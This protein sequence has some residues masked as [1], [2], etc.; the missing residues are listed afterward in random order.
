VSAST[1]LDRVVAGETEIL[2]GRT[3]GLLANP[4]SV[5]RSLVHAIDRLAAAPK[6]DLV[7]LFGPEH[8]LRGTAQ[9]MIAVAETTD[10]RTGLPVVGLYGSTL[11]T[12]APKA[13]DL[14][15][16][17]ALVFDLQDVGARYY[18][19]IWTLL[20]SMRACAD[21]GV[22]V[23]VLDR[24]NPLG[25][26]VI[27]GPPIDAGF[28]SFV[29]L[30]SLPNRHGMTAGEIARLLKSR[31][32]IG[33]ELE[34]VAMAG[35]SRSMW[36]DETGLPWVMPSPN[37]PTLETA[38]VYP[39]MCL[40]E[41]TELSEGRGTTRP[42]ELAGAPGIDSFALAE[43]L[44]AEIDGAM[45]RPVTFEPTFQ[46]HAGV[47]CGGVQIHVTDRDRYPTTRAGV[48][49]ILAAAEL[50]GER[51]DW[52]TRAYEFVDDI[53][54]IDLLAGSAKLR[55]GIDARASLA[56]LT[57]SWGASEASF[58]AEREDALLY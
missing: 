46:K 27:E 26:T 1:G 4:A 54:A 43:R 45:F 50:L 18:T 24:P 39:G 6:V 10:P 22:A 30:S 44:A 49:F 12:L 23:V 25:G 34:V 14:A 52:R 5:D 40:V 35:W 29:G 58:A 3:I 33:V 28:E 36:F 42:F 31:E 41:G 20:L 11:E 55:A 9:D 17:D 51:F 7:R 16:L 53:P 57:S 2:A 21:A 13:E 47:A 8:G 48:A 19:Y 37:M 15:G 38:V 32:A 56:E